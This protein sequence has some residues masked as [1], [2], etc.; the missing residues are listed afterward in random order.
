MTVYIAHSISMGMIPRYLPE[1]KFAWL[2]EEI[3]EEEVFRITESAA[4]VVNCMV[5]PMMDA[6]VYEAARLLGYT[7]PGP[8]GKGH[9]RLTETDTL[10]TVRYA[11]RK[12][13]P[14]DRVLP[15]GA[16]LAFYKMQIIYAKAG[17]A[18]V[19]NLINNL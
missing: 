16:S 7:I 9:V 18:E 1:K 13:V 15:E 8:D 4:Q 19:T 5:L 3:P 11:G 12:L 14:T 6:I 17:E 2:C 10:I